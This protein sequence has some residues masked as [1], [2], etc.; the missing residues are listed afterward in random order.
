[1]RYDWSCSSCVVRISGTVIFRRVWRKMDKFVVVQR[2]RKRS[3]SRERDF[4][5]RDR[6]DTSSCSVFAIQVFSSENYIGN[7]VGVP[8]TDADR[9][10]LLFN[11]RSPSSGF[12][13]PYVT[14]DAQ[15]WSF[16]KQWW[17]EFTWLAYSNIYN[18]AFCKWCVVFAPQT[19]SRS[20]KPPCSLVSEPHC[21]YK[22]AKEH[23]NNHQNCHYHKLCAAMFDNIA[24]RY[25]ML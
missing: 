3:S 8:L 5:K 16:Q 17:N 11:C 19:V 15:N 20:A 24:K 22:K 14:V 18:G 4:C 12:S 23:Y 25:E 13:F 7:F 1:M 9:R 21:N 10:K 2:K 6:N